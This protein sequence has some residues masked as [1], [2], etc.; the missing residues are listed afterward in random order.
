MMPKVVFGAVLLWTLSCASSSDVILD[1]IKKGDG[2]GVVVIQGVSIK[3]EQYAP[4]FAEVQKA[5]E[6]SLWVGIPQFTLDVPEPL[7]LFVGHQPSVAQH[8]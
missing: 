7:E 5:S 4:L 1:P 2:V 3:P 8:A 6:Y